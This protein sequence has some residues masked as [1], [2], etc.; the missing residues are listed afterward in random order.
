MDK[1]ELIYKIIKDKNIHLDK[2]LNKE[3]CNKC[4]GCCCKSC[5]CGY[6][7]REFINLNDIDYMKNILDL[8]ILCIDEL[9]LPYTAPFLTIRIR[10]KSDNNIFMSNNFKH[11]ECILLSENGCMLSDEERPIEGLLLYPKDNAFGLNEC[12]S[13]Y[14][15]NTK[16]NDWEKY[17]E[18]LKI[19]KEYY[20]NRK[21]PIKSVTDEDIKALQYKIKG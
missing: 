11:N 15:Y 17:Q 14:D 10:G 18:S 4:K 7:P 5:P 12:Y 21:V 6:S 2:F 9:V 20:I 19:L 8:G 16:I 3:K 13:M 1:L